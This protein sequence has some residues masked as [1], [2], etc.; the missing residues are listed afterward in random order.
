MEF[1]ENVSR[2][3]QGTCSIHF[4]TAAPFGHVLDGIALAAVHNTNI[5]TR[6]A[7]P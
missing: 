3:A 4:L 7:Q 2:M 1:L 5:H 6:T